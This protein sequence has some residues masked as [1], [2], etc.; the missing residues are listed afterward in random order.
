M[1]MVEL[2]GHAYTSG[3]SNVIC[4]VKY[5]QSLATAGCTFFNFIDP[6]QLNLANSFKL[7]KS[8]RGEI[9]IEMLP[10]GLKVPI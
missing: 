6:F 3:F 7:R 5:L 8:C 1:K 9:Q 4:E 10:D 2:L